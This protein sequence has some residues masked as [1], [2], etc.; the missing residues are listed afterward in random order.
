M[1]PGT[2]Y[3]AKTRPTSARARSGALL[4]PALV[5]LGRTTIACTGLISC[6]K[7]HLGLATTWAVTSLRQNQCV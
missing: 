7:Q 5:A 1:A 3:D 4:G 6:G 2:Y